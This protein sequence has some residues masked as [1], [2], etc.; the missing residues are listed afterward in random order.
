MNIV[1]DILID[2]AEAD[3][4]L[5]DKSGTGVFYD[6][7]FT[8]NENC[9]VTVPSNYA[10]TVNYGSD[11]FYVCRARIPYA[12]YSNNF[13]IGVQVEGVS[14]SAIAALPVYCYLPG[15]LFPQRIQA[16]LLPAIDID[17]DFLLWFDR[18]REAVYVYS[19]KSLDMTVGYSDSQSAQLLSLCSPGSYYRYPTLGVDVTKYVNTVVEHTDLFSRLQKQFEAD[20]KN[21]RSAEFDN[22]TGKL[23]VLFVNEPEPEEEDVDDIDSLD[24]SVFGLSD[25]ELRMLIGIRKQADFGLFYLLKNYRSLGHILLWQTDPMPWLFAKGT[26]ADEGNGVISITA[27]IPAGSLLAFNMPSI[28]NVDSPSFVLGELDVTGEFLSYCQPVEYGD[29]SCYNCI[30]VS[31]D[32]VL[33]YKITQAAL[34]NGEGIFFVKD[35]RVAIDSLMAVREDETGTRPVIVVSPQSSIDDY[36][37]WDIYEDVSDGWDAARSC[38]GNGYWIGDA[39]WLDDDTWK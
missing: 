29:N 19:A 24:K 11:G 8:D 10:D 7:A 30:I 16:S 38:F 12:P 20:L 6:A 2:T 23:D 25:K 28:S 32:T 26:T 36:I 22:R 1:R 34:N 27:N 39:P 9:V 13:N 14:S 35:T 5:T 17:G 4:V 31:K 18:D 3:I 33:Q 37:L 15:S 21:V